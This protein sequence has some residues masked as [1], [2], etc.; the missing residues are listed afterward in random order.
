M[1][2]LCTKSKK[3]KFAQK[4]FLL[5]IGRLRHILG[6]SILH[7]YGKNQERLMRQSREKL[8]TDEEMTERRTTG[9][10]KVNLKDLPVGPKILSDPV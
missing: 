4:M 3:P 1:K 5:K 2:Q 6:M 9:R 10:T 8:V 7:H